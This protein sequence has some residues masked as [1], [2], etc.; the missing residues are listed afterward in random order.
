MVQYL[1]VYSRSV[2]GRAAYHCC[3]QYCQHS[4]MISFV[5]L[6]T[7]TFAVQNVSVTSVAPGNLKLTANFLT[8]TSAVGM[9]A[10]VYSTENDSDIHY[11]EARQPQTEIQL[12]GLSGSAY[13]TSIFTLEEDGLPFNQVAHY[14][15]EISIRRGMIMIVVV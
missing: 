5:C 7:G 10:I 15:G 12:T 1:Y 2:S 11:I 9:L 4:C 6:S 14:L 8:N 13:S 3:K